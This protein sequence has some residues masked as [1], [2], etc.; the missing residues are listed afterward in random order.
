MNISINMLPYMNNKE[1]SGQLLSRWQGGVELVT[2]GADWRDNGTDWFND[3]GLPAS[4]SGQI[5]VHAPIFDLNLACPRYPVFSEYSFEVYKQSL[6][7]AA[8]IGAEHV[9]IHPNLYS[10][11]IYNKKEAQRCS[12]TYLQKLGELGKHLGVKVF[13]EN[14][15]FHECALFSA[16]EFVRLFE[17]ILSIDALLDVGHAHI[18]RWDIPEV[19]KQL[20]GRLA[21]VHLHDNYGK[22]DDHLPIGEGTIEW[23]GIWKV[24]GEASHD[25]EFILEYQIG[26][27]PETLLEHARK[28]QEEHLKTRLIK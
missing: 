27:P 19:I 20:G 28:L 11:P 9:V 6:R 3:S 15:G 2:E 23:T 10:S 25:I 22:Y 24:L 16:E 14:V 7:W 5:G 1:E 13:V 17:E 12:K 21:A 8:R 4:F 18:N 26:T